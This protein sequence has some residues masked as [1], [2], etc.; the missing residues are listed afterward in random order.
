M[1]KRT[2]KAL[3]LVL[4]SQRLAGA[5]SVDLCYNNLSFGVTECICH[6][7]INRSKILY[8]STLAKV[9]GRRCKASHLA[10]TAD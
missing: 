2:R 7:L 3:D 10:V 4:L 1:E 6:L 5:I 9:K 8:T